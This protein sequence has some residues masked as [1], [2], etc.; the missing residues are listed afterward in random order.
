[1]E[2][3][4]L[5]NEIVLKI[6]GYLGLG[7]LI[8]CAKV[9]KRFNI[10]CKDK[11]LSYRSS[12]LILKD[13]TVEDQKFVND[14]LIARPEFKEVTIHSISLEG[15]LET[16]LSRELVNWTF[17]GPKRYCM[18]KK[19]KVL[20]SQGATVCVMQVDV[21]TRNVMKILSTSTSKVHTNINTLELELYY[22][23][24]Y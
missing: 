17:M 12:K 6:L 1:M 3:F 10:I 7:D 4:L 21:R 20:K 11:S 22:H 9:S 14:F 19:M 5:P 13:L 8:Q 2:N 18:E 24:P 23:S 15:K 16:R